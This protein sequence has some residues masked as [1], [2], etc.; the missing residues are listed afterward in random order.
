MAKNFQLKT[1]IAY[2]FLIL[3]PVTVGINIVGSKH[4][5]PTVPIT[6]LLTIRF[7]LATVV[8]LPL[9]C[10]TPASKKNSIGYYFKQ[11][12]R[13]DW[14]FI[15]AQALCAG[16]LFNFLLVLGLQYTAAHTAGII[17]SALPAIISIMSW[18]V[19]KERFTLKKSLS[20]AFA[21]LG[22]LVVT[23]NS[24]ASLNSQQS[25]LGNFIVFLALLPEAVYY[26]LTKL[27]QGNL[28]IFLMSSLING[29]N[30]VI[31]LPIALYAVGW[32]SW[33]FHWTDWLIL[34][35]VGTASGLFYVFWNLGSR[36]VDAV[37]AALFTAVMPVATVSIA[38]LALGEGLN[39]SQLLGMALVMCSILA[40]A[41]S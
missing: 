22:L 30:A 13:R 37:M 40:Y 28:P 15:L 10:L 19:L 36:G 33:H 12:S 11:L 34:L 25:L 31:L 16:A 41:L 27:Y 26:V 38:W 18:A 6:V 29:I 17:T 3:A 9:H 8:V 35:L 2:C 7:F 23:V 14:A 21:T 1:V 5:I 39:L 24:S 4:L 20:V 32:H